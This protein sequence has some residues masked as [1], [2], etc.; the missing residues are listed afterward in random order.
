MESSASSGRWSGAEKKRGFNQLEGP[1]TCADTYCVVLPKWEDDRRRNA[2]WRTEPSS[3]V[4][5]SFNSG[6][7]LEVHGDVKCW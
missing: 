3:V 5:V 6:P 2:M 4:I 1:G 7:R